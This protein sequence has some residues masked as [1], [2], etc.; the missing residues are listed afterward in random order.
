[1]RPL[2][3]RELIRDIGLAAG[4]L[5]L[6]RLA[7]GRGALSQYVLE[8]QKRA[9]DEAQAALYRRGILP[10]QYL[11]ELRSSVPVLHAAQPQQRIIRAVTQE[12]LGGPVTLDEALAVGQERSHPVRRH[13]FRSRPDCPYPLCDES[14]SRYVMV[15]PQEQSF[16]TLN[17]SLE[18]R[19]SWVE[20]D[21][22]ADDPAIQAFIDQFA[23]GKRTQREM[24]VAFAT[25]L[26]KRPFG[27]IQYP[28]GI[29]TITYIF[30]EVTSPGGHGVCSDMAW[31]MTAL[32]RKID[33]P[34]GQVDTLNQEH[35]VWKGWLDGVPS[36]INAN[37]G[38]PSVYVYN[39]DGNFVYVD[40]KITTSND[41]VF[42]A[43]FQTRPVSI[44]H[45]VQLPDGAGTLEKLVL[46]FVESIDE[47]AHAPSDIAYVPFEFPLPSEVLY[48]DQAG[49]V[50]PD[51][52]EGDQAIRVDYMLRNLDG[53]LN[54]LTLRK[55]PIP[56]GN[57][58]LVGTYAN[59]RG[60]TSEPLNANLVLPAWA[61]G[62]METKLLAS[63]N[64]TL[65]YEW[66]VYFTNCDLNPPSPDG[67]R[68]K[69]ASLRV[70]TLGDNIHL[71]KGNNPTP[72]PPARELIDHL[73]PVAGA[74]LSNLEAL[75]RYAFK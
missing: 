43:G 60:Y 15:A 17:P 58:G 12:L 70:Q 10:P 74:D 44:W 32:G 29:P 8:A 18:N 25:E 35:A 69:F 47:S 19:V 13:L 4:G 21:S 66:I 3:R 40:N 11:K 56:Y 50:H 52:R 49:R 1:M 46:F 31:L 65:T 72:L 34:G 68:Q 45:D 57:M 24:M 7:S 2:D 71:L 9:V 64:G 67:T 28:D 16:Y 51:R 73:E 59:V 6:A 22:W 27:Y 26:S 5:S 23:S 14:F 20:Q 48:A 54:P 62:T 53:P 63:R 33:A 37:F 36:V 75:K 61:S 42:L 55:R 41:E 30:R 39:P 38:W